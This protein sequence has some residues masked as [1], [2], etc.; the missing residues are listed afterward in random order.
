MKQ[1]QSSF[2]KETQEWFCRKM[3]FA[4]FGCSDESVTRN[5]RP[6]LCSMS[7]VL[8]GSIYKSERKK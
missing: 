8:E 6:L 1:S 3:K 5:D 2:E 4:H 7:Y